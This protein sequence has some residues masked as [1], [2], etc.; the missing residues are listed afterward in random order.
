MSKIAKLHLLLVILWV[1]LIIP[2][3][4][5]WSESILWVAFMSVYA[6]IATHWDAYQSARAVAAGESLLPNTEAPE[7]N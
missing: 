5:L 7:R 2:T 4:L 1:I 3:V 6:I